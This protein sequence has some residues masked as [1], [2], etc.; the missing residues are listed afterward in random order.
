MS[1]NETSAR[2]D[3]KYAR[4]RWWEM[5]YQDVRERLKDGKMPNA[6]LHDACQIALKKPCQIPDLPHF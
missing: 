5:P 2:S 4:I 3:T 1:N 6:R